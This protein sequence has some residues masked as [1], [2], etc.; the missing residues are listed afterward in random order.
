M[1]LPASHPEWG[2]APPPDHATAARRAR[3]DLLAQ[4]AR[5]DR[6]LSCLFCSVFPRQ[7]F[8]WSVASPGGGPRLLSLA[9]LEGLRDRLLER[10]QQNRLALAERTRAEDQARRLIEAMMLA[11]EQHKWV[12]VRAEQIGE[13]GCKDWHVRPRFGLLGM[14]L[15]WWR[16]CISSG[17]P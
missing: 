8:E 13:R 17:C 14:M 12:R 15:N 6:E 1:L 5:L 4:I 9:E 7:G 2:A 3:G 11:P 10:L 16:V